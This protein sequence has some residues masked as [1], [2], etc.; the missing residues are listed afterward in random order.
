[1]LE[2]LKTFSEYIREKEDMSKYTSLKI[3]GP[4]DI[5]CKVPSLKDL[6]QLVKL[7]NQKNIFYLVIGQGS[8]LLIKD[9]G[10]RGV[11]I[12]LTNEF[13]EMKVVDDNS[14]I[15]KSGVSLS[16]LINYAYQN[17]LAGLEA[18]CGIPASLGGAIYCQAKA[19]G[20]SII[21][22]ISFIKVLTKDGER[23][24]IYHNE[25]DYLFKENG[26]IITEA[27]LSLEKST[28]DKIKLMIDYF[29]DIRKK[30]QPIEAKTAGCIFKNPK[31][32]PP[33]GWLIEKA[34]L[35]GKRFNDVC[36]SPI[37]AN[38]IQNLNKAKAKDLLYLIELIKTKVKEKFGIELEE[39]VKI[40][41][42]D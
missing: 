14:I 19:F 36:I 39:E 12:K 40:Y 18:L 35:K 34:G 21:E 3:G 5:F 37:H 26:F 1:M 4:A 27:C 2:K 11:V 33:A 15:A 25:L 41:G 28:K 10:I 16:K 42:Q 31:G 24:I 17:R 22:F 8:N 7:L 29:Q 6:I 30:T 23:K 32:Y 9:G 13:E 20:K 38:F